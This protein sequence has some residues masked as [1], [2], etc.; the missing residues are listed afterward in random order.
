MY[1]YIYIYTVYTYIYVCVYIYT[2]TSVFLIYHMYP[3]VCLLR[4]VSQWI[5][6]QGS[7][8]IF[9]QSV[10]VIFFPLPQDALYVNMREQIDKKAIQKR[11]EQ[12]GSPKF[13]RPFEDGKWGFFTTG[14]LGSQ[15]KAGVGEPFLDGIVMGSC[16]WTLVFIGFYGSSMDCSAINRS[17][18][19]PQNQLSLRQWKIF[20]VPSQ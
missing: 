16:G 10:P 11:S 17:W 19:T 9:S 8:T 1:V 5:K 14:V 13:L 7:P 3:Y 12:L 2:H 4:V 6:D 18:K 20:F 15:G